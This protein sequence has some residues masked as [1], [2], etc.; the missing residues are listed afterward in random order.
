MYGSLTI[1]TLLI[2]SVDQRIYASLSDWL[3]QRERLEARRNQAEER[4]QSGY[5]Y[6]DRGTIPDRG[7]TVQEITE[8]CNITKNC[9]ITGIS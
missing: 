5:I 6:P 7:I 3:V 8:N 9:N 2:C 4:Y 1:P